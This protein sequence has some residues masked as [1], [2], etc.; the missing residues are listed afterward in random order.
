MPVP[1]LLTCS[2]PVCDAV[3]QIK[4]FDPEDDEDITCPECDNDLEWEFDD[5]TN[6][7]KLIEPDYEE[8]GEDIIG[9]IGDDDEDEDE[10]DGD[11]EA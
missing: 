4:D 3:I 6:E 9:E 1:E 2:C 10:D 11:D 5:T 7:L 8:E